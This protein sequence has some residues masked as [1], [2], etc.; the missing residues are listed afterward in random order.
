MP[1]APLNREFTPQP[2]KSAHHHRKEWKGTGKTHIG[3][4]KHEEKDTYDYDDDS[5]G[6]NEVKLSKE[7]IQKQGLYEVPEEDERGSS[8]TRGQPLVGV[9]ASAVQ[10]G[11]YEVPNEGDREEGGDEKGEQNREE[12]HRGES[13]G[14]VQ[15]TR[16]SRRGEWP[17]KGMKHEESPTPS[18][19]SKLESAEHEKQT[20]EEYEDSEVLDYAKKYKGQGRV[21]L[22]FS[23]GKENAKI[24]VYKYSK[25]RKLDDGVRDG[26]S[27]RID[28]KRS[29][30]EKTAVDSTSYK[31]AVLRE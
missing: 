14:R 8:E 3:G 22:D 27:S 29:S 13:K 26:L 25:G 6:G 28:K 11:L 18:S 17:E 31:K 20:G 19:M 12:E 30:V 7:Q 1:V 15:E 24:I 21:V 2:T 16:G 10:K 23:K 9:S 5:S 4:R